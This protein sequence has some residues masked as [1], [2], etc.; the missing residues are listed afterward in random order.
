MGGGGG[1][2]GNAAAAA[3]AAA[4]VAAAGA[5]IPPK[6][7]V[8]AILA[9]RWPLS[10]QEKEQED[11]SGFQVLVFVEAGFSSGSWHTWQC[12][13]AVAM[14]CLCGVYPLLCL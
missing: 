1:T 11:V 5:P 9:W 4:A 7:T 3:V 10:T 12:S 13:T 14:H 8:E 6:N 2:A